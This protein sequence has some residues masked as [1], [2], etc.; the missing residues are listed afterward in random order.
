MDD[1]VLTATQAIS[2]GLVLNELLTNSLKYAF[3]ESISNPEIKISFRLDNDS[4]YM[5]YED[6]GV[7]CDIDAIKNKEDSYGLMLIDSMAEKVDGE[8]KYCGKSGF[9]AELVCNVNNINI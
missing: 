1:V 7:G 5:I 9:R 3:D 4:F 2:T 6:N 8:L